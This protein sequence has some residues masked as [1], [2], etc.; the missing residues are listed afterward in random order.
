VSAATGDLLAYQGPSSADKTGSSAGSHE[1]LDLLEELGGS[2][3]ASTLF[4]QYVLTPFELQSM[5]QRDKARAAY[6]QFVDGSDGWGAPLAIRAAMGSWNFTR[7][8]NLI[9]EARAILQ[10]RDEIADTLRPLGRSVPPVLQQ[11]YESNGELNLDAL[12]DEANHDLEAA[13]HIVDANS[14]VQSSH[15]ILGSFGLLYAGANDKVHQAENALEKG[16]A[17]A[18]ITL[19]DSARRQAQDATRAGVIRLV[20]LLLVLA[21]A[22]ALWTWGRPF[23]LRRLE[24]RAEKRRAARTALPLPQWPEWAPPPPPYYPPGPER[25][26][27]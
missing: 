8:T 26:E 3:Q 17:A 18:A 16:D 2:K 5:T 9:P 19:A 22:Y 14:A 10:T 15:G 13:H 6:H 21:T 11:H 7:A 25:D 12:A 1:L 27:G 20:V 23:V 24:V 4:T